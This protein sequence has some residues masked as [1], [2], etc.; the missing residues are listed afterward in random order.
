MCISI[1][2]DLLSF[3]A[4][5]DDAIC[6]LNRAYRLSETVQVSINLMA[7][8]PAQHAASREVCKIVFLSIHLFFS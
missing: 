8:D 4:Q 1:I 7:R 2:C 5:R 6:N 3:P